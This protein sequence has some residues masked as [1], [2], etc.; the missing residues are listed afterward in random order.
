MCM[1]LYPSS[2]AVAS[3]TSGLKTV[4]K[5][6]P[7]DMGQSIKFS[8]HKHEDLSLNFNTYVK[9]QVWW[10]AYIRPA[11]GTQRQ[12][13]TTGVPGVSSVN[14]LQFNKYLSLE[15]CI[16]KQLRQTASALHTHI[17][18]NIGHIHTPHKIIKRNC[19]YTYTHTHTKV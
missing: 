12:E 10:P 14:E 1:I 5:Q 9:T 13:N 8:L 16:R 17:Q 2:A 19:I 6:G 18:V 4:A 7:E 15:K 11:Q 3:T